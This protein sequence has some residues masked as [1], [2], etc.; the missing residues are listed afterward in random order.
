MKN[1]NFL[2]ISLFCLFSL[3]AMSLSAQEICNN[4]IDD[5]GDG[6]IDLNDSDCACA[7]IMASSLIPNPSFEDM[8]CCPQFEAQLDCAVDWIQASVP[9]TDYVHTCGIIGNPK[10]RECQF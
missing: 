5:D 8:N 9:T 7:D 2:R 1:F 6:L 3:A 4:A 10:T